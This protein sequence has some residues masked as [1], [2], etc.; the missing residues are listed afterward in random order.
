MVTRYKTVIAKALGECKVIRLSTNKL[1]KAVF[2]GKKDT[3]EV[4][5]NLDDL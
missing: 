4:L 1:I 5:N 3:H 2:V